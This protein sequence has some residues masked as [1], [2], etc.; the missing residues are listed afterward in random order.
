MWCGIANIAVLNVIICA[1]CD[2]KRVEY[3]VSC[4]QEELR[5]AMYVL[6]GIRRIWINVVFPQWH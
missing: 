6:R 2:V 1:C 5:T 3:H 4:F